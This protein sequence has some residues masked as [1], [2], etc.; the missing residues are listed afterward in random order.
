MNGDNVF[1]HKEIDVSCIGEGEITIVELLKALESGKPLNTVNGIMF[2]DEN[3]KIARTPPRTYIENLDLLAHPFTYAKKT[4]KDFDRYP[5]EAFSNVF[6]SRGCPYA[7]TFCESKAMW[8][9]KVRY[10]S[11]Q[12]IVEELKQLRDFGIKRVS[13]EDDTFGVSKKYK[14]NQ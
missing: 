7:C 4:L 12:N 8:T 6:A 11:P 5:K 3:N 13:F 9:R 14:S 10:R 1:E 2:R